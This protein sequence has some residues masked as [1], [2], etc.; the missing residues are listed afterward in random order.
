[1]KDSI[2]KLLMLFNKKE[3]KRLLVLL[4]MMI[5]AALF[6]TLGIGMIVPIVGVLTNPDII[7]NQPVLSYLYT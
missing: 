7:Q 1:M 3:K 2:K 6:E 4:L 5:A